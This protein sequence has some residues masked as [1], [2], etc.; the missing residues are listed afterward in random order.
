MKSS[1][2]SVSREGISIG[3]SFSICT[4]IYVAVT[5]ILDI[6]RRGVDLKDEMIWKAKG[7]EGEEIRYAKMDLKRRTRHHFSWDEIQCRLL[8]LF[9]LVLTL[10]AEDLHHTRPVNANF[11]K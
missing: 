9:R 6:L 10:V 3:V 2:V 4:Y 5:M 11:L 7:N 1:G 8:H